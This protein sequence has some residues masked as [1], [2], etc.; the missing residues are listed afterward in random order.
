MPAG[1]RLEADVLT[2]APFLSCLLSM[3]CF[4]SGATQAENSPSGGH[5]FRAVSAVDYECVIE[6]LGF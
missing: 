5:V 2:S 6:G 1:D 4:S 3:S